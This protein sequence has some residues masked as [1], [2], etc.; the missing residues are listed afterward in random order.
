MVFQTP[1][2]FHLSDR[3]D[4]L[5]GSAGVSMQAVALVNP[6]WDGGDY[7]VDAILP[8]G[9]IDHAPDLTP[10]AQVAKDALYPTPNPAEFL[11]NVPFNPRGQMRSDGTGLASLAEA[12][13]WSA[14]V[15]L[16]TPTGAIVR[17]PH[18]GSGFIASVMRGN[19]LTLDALVDEA[20]RLLDEDDT[21]YAVIELEP[22]LRADLT[23]LLQADLE[24]LAGV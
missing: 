16:L 6:E 14:R 7:I 12:A 2:Y 10:E 1:P 3:L 19:A 22:D 4:A 15:R 20:L 5:A 11:A 21:W 8:T 23:L 9:P 17:Q 24:L 18:I 13:F